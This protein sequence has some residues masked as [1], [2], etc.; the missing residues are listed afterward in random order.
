[1]EQIAMSCL[2]LADNLE[3]SLRNARHLGNWMTTSK[4]SDLHTLSQIPVCLKGESFYLTYICR[5]YKL[6]QA[7]STKGIKT[8]CGWDLLLK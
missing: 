1:M 7:A 2:I 8:L 3:L 4:Q 6:N 5:N